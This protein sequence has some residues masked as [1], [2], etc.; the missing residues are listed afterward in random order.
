MIH[1]SSVGPQNKSPVAKFNLVCNTL[2][3]SQYE[4]T[5]MV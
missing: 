1:S 2:S 4:F 5:H 3:E